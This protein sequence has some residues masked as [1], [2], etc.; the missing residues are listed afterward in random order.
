MA[1]THSLEGRS[2]EGRSLEGRTDYGHLC[3]QLRLAGLLDRRLV[4]YAIKTSLTL[5]ALAAGWSGFALLGNSWATLG[6]A[7]FLGL[8][9]SQV[10]FLGHDAGHQQIFSRRRNNRRMGLV[11]GNLLTG[12]SFGWWVPKHNAHHAFPNQENRDPDI[13]AGVISFTA[14]QTSARRG[15]GRV[16]ARHQAAL[17]FPLLFLEGLNLHVSSVQTLWRQRAERPVRTEVI[18]LAVHATLFLGAVF[19][20]LP[21]GKAVAFIAVQQGV[22]GLCLGCS[23]APNHKGMPLITRDSDRSFAHRQVITAR[24]VTGGW[25]GSFLLGG[26]D[27]Q[28]E[29]HLFPTMPRPNLGRA[30]PYVRAFCLE[31][32]LPYQ[33]VGVVSSYRQALRHLRSI[34]SGVGADPSLA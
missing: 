6:I 3:H 11:V 28:I 2:L 22:F 5:L 17:F 33:E 14:V 21:V 7:A 10:V 34:G 8:A 25:L 19:A 1:I 4:Y 26:L 12:L 9:F 13:A 24:N 32:G 27:Y 29:H 31:H 15:F 23:F 30:Q 20:V 18:L 16:F